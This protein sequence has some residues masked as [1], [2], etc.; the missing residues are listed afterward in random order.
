M[1]QNKRKS[2]KAHALGF[3]SNGCRNIASGTATMSFVNTYMESMKHMQ[4]S[5]V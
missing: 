3:S 2:K 5:T 4:K 1:K